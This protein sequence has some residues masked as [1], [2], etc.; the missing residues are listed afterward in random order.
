MVIDTQIGKLT[1]ISSDGY[2]TNIIFG[3]KDVTE[4]EPVLEQASKQIMEYFAGTRK[5]FDVPIKPDGGAFCKK[6]WEVMG[7]NVGYGKTI[8]YGELAKLCGNEK[9]ARA[10][11]MANNRNPIPII[12][13][14]HRV[15]GKAGALTG[16][17]WGLDVK[18]KLL[19]HE[20][21]YTDDKRDNSKS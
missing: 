12:I 2:L 17:R 6:V 14:C 7:S 3:E 21:L 19:E 11:G 13:P 18:Q 5:N 9:A 15:M 20:F 1:L 16:F 10:V 8:S 4:H